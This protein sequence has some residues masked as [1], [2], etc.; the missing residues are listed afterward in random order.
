MARNDTRI[1]VLLIANS[2]QDYD[3]PA[4][5]EPMVGMVKAAAATL[6]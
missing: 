2:G 4:G 6:A 3:Y 1:T 5:K